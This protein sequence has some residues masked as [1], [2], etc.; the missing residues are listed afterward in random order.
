MTV[1]KIGKVF[2][3]NLPDLSQLDKFLAVRR[4]EVLENIGDETYMVISSLPVRSGDGAVFDA[5]D[6]DLR[7]II[8][9]PPRRVML[10][11]G[12]GNVACGAPYPTANGLRADN[13][14]SSDSGEPFKGNYME[15][16]ATGYVEYGQL[17]KASKDERLGLYFAA[18]HHSAYIV[19]FM[20]FIEKIYGIYL[21][22]TPLVVNFAIYNARG[23]WLAIAGN[24]QRDVG[25]D[26]QHLELGKFYTEN[27]PEECK[28]LTKAICDRIWQAFHR[29]GSADFDESGEFDYP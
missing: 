8:T 5:G 16:Y 28:L 10:V 9:H 11:E 7:G 24:Y 25:W 22:V 1:D 15:V 21:P 3:Q 26:Q 12:L 27:F 14:S 13:R 23:I 20:A 4:A 18:V 6:Q 2:D 17:I 29:E 19:N